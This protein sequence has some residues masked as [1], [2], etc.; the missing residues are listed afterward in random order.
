MTPKEIAG[1][2]AGIQSWEAAP[3]QARNAFYGQMEKRQYGHEAITSA[4][5]W[6]FTG[7]NNYKD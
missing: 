3:V 4:W 7:W 5:A 1:E 2:L 6:F